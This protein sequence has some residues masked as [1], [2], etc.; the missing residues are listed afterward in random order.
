MGLVD[1]YEHKGIKRINEYDNPSSF[2]NDFE[3]AIEYDGRNVFM[4]LTRS[5]QY[6]GEMKSDGTM[7]F[8]ASIN[9]ITARHI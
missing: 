2:V 5:L 7:F 6:Y 8:D 3:N 4:A 1:V 9:H